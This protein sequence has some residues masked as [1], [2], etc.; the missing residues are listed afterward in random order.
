VGRPLG[1]WRRW[2]LR[3]VLAILLLLRRW[4]L[5]LMGMGLLHRARARAMGLRTE[6]DDDRERWGRTG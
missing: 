1:A 2:A 3:W 4:Q 6:A 5:L